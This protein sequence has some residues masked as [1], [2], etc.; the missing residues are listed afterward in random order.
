MCFTP[1]S[2][3]C[4]LQ[5][6]RD[7]KFVL[8]KAGT[9]SPAVLNSHNHINNN[10]NNNT[11]KSHHV[12][13]EVHARGG[14]PATNGGIVTAY[15]DGDGNHGNKPGEARV[16][17]ED[18]RNHGVARAHSNGSA[19][20]D[21]PAVVMGN[22]VVQRQ[23]TV[24]EPN[25][26]STGTPTLSATVAPAPAAQT[27]N[28]FSEVPA[29]TVHRHVTTELVQVPD[30]GRKLSTA[31]SARSSLRVKFDPESVRRSQDRHHQFRSLRTSRSSGVPSTIVRPIE[32]IYGHSHGPLVVPV[33]HSRPS[34]LK[35]QAAPPGDRHMP[36][37]AMYV[38]QQQQQQHQPS[39]AVYVAQNNAPNHPQPQAYMTAPTHPVRRSRPNSV[40]VMDGS[41][42]KVFHKTGEL[43]DVLL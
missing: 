27:S 7:I 21:K 2:P 30:V 38:A 4:L 11:D 1:S 34:I 17:V 3:T 35:R 12:L 8:E 25:T 43:D 26:S 23:I 28:G 14:H 39:N 37:R 40:H 6:L 19:L 5:E 32:Q 20:P 33:V 42:L 9:V 13:S 29:Y 31:E 24:P 18:Y 10:N 41:E 16:T 22:G 15:S 36:V